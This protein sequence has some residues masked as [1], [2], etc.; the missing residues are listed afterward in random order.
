MTDINYPMQSSIKRKTIT[1]TTDLAGNLL[2]WPS[3]FNIIIPIVAF[4][5]KSDSTPLS[6]GC[7]FYQGGLICM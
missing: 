2:L 7:T 5:Y 3:G 6:C 4:C 1:G